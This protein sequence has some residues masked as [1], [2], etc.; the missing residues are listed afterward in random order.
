MNDAAKSK[1]QLLS[2]LSE[3]RQRVAQLQPPER[4]GASVTFCESEQSYRLLAELSHDFI[5]IV[6][7]DGRVQYVNAA[8]ARELGADPRTMVGRRLEEVF[9]GKLTERQKRGV[10]QVVR[11]GKPLSFEGKASLP[12][13]EMWLDTLLVP[14]RSETGE[15]NAALGIARNVTECKEAEDALQISRAELAAIITERKQAEAALH[16]SQRALLTLMSNLPGMAYRCRVDEHWTTELVSEGCLDLTGH[17]AS[18][19]IGNAKLHYS[20]LIHPDDRQALAEEVAEALHANRPYQFVYRIATASGQEKWVWEKGRGVL[21][22][23]G[24]PRAI[25]GLITDIT[26]RKRADEERERMQRLLLQAQKMEAIG[27]LAGGVAHDFNNLLTTIHGHAELALSDLDENDPLYK[28]LDRIRHAALRGASLTS[29]LLLFSRR[30]LFKTVPLSLN[31]T[32]HDFLEMLE[33]VIGE[34]IDIRTD[35]HPEIW[36]LRGDEGSLE[37]MIMNLAVNARDAMPDGGTLTLATDCVTLGPDDCKAIPGARPGRFVCLTIADTGVGMDQ[38]VLQHIFEP[39]FTTK[40]AGKGTGLGCSVVYGIVQ[41]HDG[42]INVTS[43]PGCGTTFRI[44]LPA[45]EE[46]PRVEQDEHPPLDQLD[47]HGERILL[48]EDEEGVRA[49]AQKALERHGYSVLVATN[50]REALEIFAREGGAFDLVLS[51]VVL[52]DISGVQLVD[53]LLTGKPGLKVLL[54]SGYAD[55]KSQWPIIRDRGFPFIQKP[56]SLADL[57]SLI[58][59]IVAPAAKA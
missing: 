16:E 50:A 17:A 53:H 15:I 27:I 29:Q 3:L 12:D 59:D 48:V 25:E 6:D 36:T 14:I 58:R 57:L 38:D 52:P 56:Y 8:A 41:Q 34:D 26:E 55:Q 42:W 30:Q 51:D 39:F 43:Q 22:P 18:D 32:V 13:R 37:Q 21:G 1:A 19:F 9:P 2:E 11:S 4:P 35:L 47:G 10:R 23:D 45:I 24:S 44:Y 46:K 31:A 40:E 5:F 33:R 54:T 49:F 28:E 20:Q 7:N